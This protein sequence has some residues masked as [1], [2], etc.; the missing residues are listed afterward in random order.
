MKNTK[1]ANLTNPN[2][3]ENQ[4]EAKAEKPKIK[5]SLKMCVFVLRVCVCVC[6]CDGSEGKLCSEGAVLLFKASNTYRFYCT[7]FKVCNWDVQVKS[8]QL[9]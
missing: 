2:G 5:S 7:L 4:K 8:V 3:A 6:D 1:Q 9:G